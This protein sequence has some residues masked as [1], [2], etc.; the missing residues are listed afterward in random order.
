M[1]NLAFSKK[2]IFTLFALLLGVNLWGQTL[3][4]EPGN[5]NTPGSAENPYLIYSAADW[6]IF[7]GWINAG[8]H[9][10][11]HYKLMANIPTAAEISAGTSGVTTKVGTDDVSFYGDF[12]GKGYTINVDYIGTNYMAPFYDTYDATIHDLN[13]TGNIVVS[14]G[15]SAGLI[16][17]NYG[18]TTI[19]NVTVSVNIKNSNNGSAGNY[20]AGFA[21]DNLE[22]E[23][24]GIINFV[25]CVYNGTIK[26][27]NNS[28]GFCPTMS[29]GST[30]FTNCIF[31]PAEGSYITSGSTFA[32]N[33][34]LLTGCY[35]TSLAGTTA[36][37]T[38]AY[39]TAPD[40]D[41]V[42]KVTYNGYTVYGHVGVTLPNVEA[43][44]EYNNGEAITVNCAVTFDGAAIQTGDY[45]VKIYKDGTEVTQVKDCGKHDVVV[46]GTGSKGSYYGAY[47]K[48]FYVIKE[49]AGTGDEGTPYI[50][51]SEGDWISLAYYVN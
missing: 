40:D 18:T 13:V 31:D 7:A 42:K 35:Y 4:T 30:T 46:A 15:L 16:G 47:T 9:A 23:D 41:F 6:D 1:K 22:Y 25:R 45:T 51:A 2:F 49:L 43:T 20:C 14:E 36:Q 8:Q 39:Q 12:D 37:G 38:L 27:G 32:A 17:V 33:N 44:Y 28:G 48:S 10:Y 29:G 50:I 34:T 11:D 19:T 5:E 3:P 21:I 24:Y 26:A